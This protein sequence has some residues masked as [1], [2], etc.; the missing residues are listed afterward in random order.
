MKKYLQELLF[1]YFFKANLHSFRHF[2][3]IKNFKFHIKDCQKS[4][5]KKD[6]EINIIDRLMYN[7]T[8]NDRQK[9]NT[10]NNLF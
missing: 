2:F 3:N 10:Y 6:M 5:S 7:F 8:Y 9:P 1:E 4:R